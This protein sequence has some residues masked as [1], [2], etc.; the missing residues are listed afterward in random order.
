MSCV[1]RSTQAFGIILLSINYFQDISKNFHPKSDETAHMKTVKFDT[2][3][4]QQTKKTKQINLAE[5]R[6]NKHLAK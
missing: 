4:L 5:K 6:T 1:R 3:K 2:R